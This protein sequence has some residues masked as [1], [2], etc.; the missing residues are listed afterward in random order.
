[1]RFGIIAN[2][3]SGPA[4]ITRKWQL[5]RKVAEILGPQTLIAGL[6]TGSREEFAQ[7]AKD[8]VAKVDVMIV[9]GG[10]G[11]FSDMINAIDIAIAVR[12]A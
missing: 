6:D 3:K 12:T 1:M 9:A 11:T 7:C 2:P 10:D 5:L 4:S 8:L